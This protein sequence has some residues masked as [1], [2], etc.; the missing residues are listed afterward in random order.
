VID[1]LAAAGLAAVGQWTDTAERYAVTLAE[2][3]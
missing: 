2:P 1:E 3:A